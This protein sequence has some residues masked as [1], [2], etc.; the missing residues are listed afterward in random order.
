M[1]WLKTT[2]FPFRGAQAAEVLLDDIQRERDVETDLESR[3]A[4]EASNT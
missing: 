1:N 3:H 2:Q 4:A